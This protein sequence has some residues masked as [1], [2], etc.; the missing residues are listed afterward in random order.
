MHTETWPED[1]RVRGHYENPAVDGRWIVQKIVTRMWN[2]F[3]QF[4]IGANGGLL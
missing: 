1:L 3:F 4:I 2:D